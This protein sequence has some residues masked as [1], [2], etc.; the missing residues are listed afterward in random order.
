M[1]KN[2][3]AVIGSELLDFFIVVLA[4]AIL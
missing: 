4:V 3:F 1:K 2:I